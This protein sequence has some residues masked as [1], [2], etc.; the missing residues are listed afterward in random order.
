MLMFDIDTHNQ[1]V[2]EDRHQEKEERELRNRLLNMTNTDKKQELWRKHFPAVDYQE[3][4]L[5]F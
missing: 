4:D 3:T 5:I 2:L 1:I